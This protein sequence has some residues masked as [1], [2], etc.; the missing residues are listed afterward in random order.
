MDISKM[1]KR[2]CYAGEISRR[3]I[4]RQV[5][6]NGWVNRVRDHG[7]LIFLDLRDRTG[8][9]QLVLSAE[10]S[11]EAF[12]RA[13]E[14]K[15]EYVLAVTGE[16]KERPE[17]TVNPHLKTG[18]IE[19]Y[20]S[21][22]QILNTAKVPPFL[23]SEEKEVEEALRLRY[24]Y[25]D[26][27]RPEMQTLLATRHRAVKLIRDFLNE[28]GFW[29]IETPVLTRSTPEGAR[30]YLVPSRTYP[31]NFFALPQ[32]PQLF[33]QLLMVAGVEKYFQIARC[34]RDEDLRADRQPE[35]T[36]LDLEMSFVTPAEIMDLT[37]A[38]LAFLFQKL[39]NKDL[40]LPFPRLGYTE[41][42][43]RFGTD[44]P[45]L[46]FGLELKEVTSLVTESGFKVFAEAVRRKES[47]KGLRVPGGGR[48]SRREME[49]LT[50][51]ATHLGAKGLTWLVKEKEGFRSPVA[52]FFTPAE[53]E[54]LGTALAAREGDLLLFVAS[55][56]ARANF[57]LST[58]RLELGRE[59][60]LIPDSAFSFVWL[61]DFPLLEYL[62][63]EKRFTAVHHPF[64]AP[65]AADLPLLESEPLKVR[66]QAYDLVLNG[67]E[68]GGGS[69]RIHQRP[70]QEKIFRLLGLSAPEY[71]EKF[72][73]LLE[74]LDY[75]APPHG[76]I[77]L[78]LDRLLMLL[79]GRE[80]IRDVIAFPKTQSATCLLT[81]APAPVAPSQLQEL[82][83]KVTAPETPSRE[84]VAKGS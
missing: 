42:L 7:S 35:F 81:K 30:D 54:G 32:S 21:E 46:R 65:L 74:A 9:V 53:L 27:R 67:V 73:F 11:P 68:L 58:L 41:A 48:F 66:S 43:A 25:L 61:I 52:K 26:L 13:K 16:V 34:F 15:S 72:G 1:L 78:G 49:L 69:I 83:L 64:T 71:T 33:K 70:L 40:L 80:T 20:V 76:G 56:P 60:G 3:D 38:L 2:T 84:K 28:H 75:G 22:L 45:D 55:N 44:R 59:L 8:V 6:L 37:E 39:W 12:Q 4:G 62:P 47:V 79:L 36:Q 24:R 31:G 77:A 14:I 5:T 63:E 82:H 10:V 50:A 18:E 17:G 19:V 23:P 57:V 51:K 29:E